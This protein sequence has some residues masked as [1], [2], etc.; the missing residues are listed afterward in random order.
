MVHRIQEVRDV[1]RLDGGRDV[2]ATGVVGVRRADHR[3]VPPG[4]HEHDASVSDGAEHDR[5]GM[6][7]PCAGND[8]V[9]P[10]GEPEPRRSR[11]VEGTHLVDPRPGRVDDHPGPHQRLAAPQAIDHPCTD[12]PP[13]LLL[14][15]LDLGVRGD[16]RA[17]ARRSH[18]RLEHQSRIVRPVVPVEPTA[19]EPLAAQ[20][21]LGGLH[22]APPEHAVTPNLP[23]AGQ[24]VVGRE[25]CREFQP[26]H[27][28]APVDREEKWLRTDEMRCEAAEALALP[29]GL[30]DEPD[31][32]LLEVAEATVNQLRGPARRAGREVSPLDERRPQPAHDGVTCDPGPVDPASDHE[33]VEG[34]TVERG[35]DGSA[36]GKR[37]GHEGIVVKVPSDVTARQWRSAIRPSV[38]AR[39]VARPPRSR[40]RTRPCRRSRSTARSI[41]PAA[42]F[43][44]TWRSNFAPDMMAASGL[45]RF[46]P[47]ISGAVPCTASKSAWRLPTFAPGTS[48]SPPTRPAHRSETMSP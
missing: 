5:G 40:V 35:P 14:E 4:D 20:R 48:P 47:A 16:C 32:R 33:H 10:L 6:T 31:L 27:R 46:F 42:C 15:R 9:Y 11:S 7:N 12:D 41:R 13:P 30:E 26:P 2:R 36:L 38:T 44:P 3:V 43:C 8:E 45:A 17:L 25:T 19:L 21:R 18:R 22:R 29:H 37:V 39:V 24:E 28:S 34:V 23:E 1:R